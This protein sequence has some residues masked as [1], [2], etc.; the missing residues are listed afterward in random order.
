MSWCQDKKIMNKAR[1]YTLDLNGNNSGDFLIIIHGMFEFIGHIPSASLFPSPS[2]LT[3]GGWWHIRL[4]DKFRCNTPTPICISRPGQR[5]PTHGDMSRQLHV[6][7]THPSL[8]HSFFLSWPLTLVHFLFT[9]PSLYP[10]RLLCLSHARRLPPPRAMA[11]LS[12]AVLLHHFAK[13]LHFVD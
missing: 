12:A 11:A 4:S 7:H 2:A 10:T 6:R 9:L 3:L 5:E 13:P 1:V 8:C